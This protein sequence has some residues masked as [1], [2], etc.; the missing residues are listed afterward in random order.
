M[1]NTAVN[2]SSSGSILASGANAAKG[3]KS[4]F[5]QFLFLLT[6]QLKNQDPLEPM[7]TTDFTN[8]LVQFSNVEQG[9]KSNQNLQALIALQ[10]NNTNVG[11]IGYIGKEVE[12]TGNKLGLSANALPVKFKYALPDRADALT[13]KIKNSEGITVREFE[14]SAL[15]GPHDMTWDGKDSSGTALPDG[16]YTLEVKAVKNNNGVPKDLAVYTAMTGKVDFVSIDPST[17]T[18]NLSIN[19]LLV[20]IANIISIRQ[21]AN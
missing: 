9:I 14:G 20:P 6:Q 19:G 7:N 5:D 21:A 15:A 3:K 8:Q 13:V 17:N 11:A 2:N 4:D 16:I 12:L 1:E 18:P 10:Q